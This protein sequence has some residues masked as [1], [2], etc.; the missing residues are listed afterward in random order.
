AEIV[1]G[2]VTEP[3]TLSSATKDIDIVIHA[4][5]VIHPGL[6]KVHDLYKVNR[7]G[8][9]NMLVASV[10]GR[11]KRFI[12]ISSNSACGINKKRS[13]MMTER[14]KP[15]PYTPYGISK[16]QA[17]QIVRAFQ[18]KG[19]I[20]TV[21]LRPCWFYGPGQPDRQTTLMKMIK[22]GKP[23]LFGDGD[24]L[25]SMSYIGNVIQGI[26]LAM[27]KE[28]AIGQIYWI[29]DERPYTTNEIYGSIAKHLGVNELKP[30]KIPRF[31]S[32]LMEIADILLS[33]I[34][35]YLIQIHVGGEMI[36]DIACSIAKAKKEL[37][38]SPKHSL[39]DGMKASVDFAIEKGQL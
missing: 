4:A 3:E 12:Y 28:N 32:E 34:G 10:A 5:G 24:N 13:A 20:Q 17:E 19:K 21:I 26:R 37:G 18:E 9:R 16:F 30:R 23:L 36:R 25:R 15:G 11:V 8:T 1:E 14:T 33:K 7:D 27:E 39:D 35:I 2:D 29:A 38:Y 22:S 31:V 6:L